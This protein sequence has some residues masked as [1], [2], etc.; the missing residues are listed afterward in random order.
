MKTRTKL[1]L[2]LLAVGGIAYGVEA[3]KTLQPFLQVT[4]KGLEGCKLV[5]APGLQ[6]AEDMEVDPQTGVFFMTAAQRNTGSAF[7]P[8]DGGVFRYRPDVDKAP[9]RLAIEGFAAELRPHGIGLLR[10]PSER[11]VFLIQH[12]ETGESVEI[13]RLEE[14]PER[15]TLRH[16]R[17]VTDP[18][19]K[20]INDVAP[21]A[22]EAFYVT[23]DHGRRG[24]LGHM[25]E[26]FLLLSNASIVYFDGSKGTLAASGL[27]YANG[28]LAD[29]NGRFVLVA[30]TTARRLRAF[31]R[32]SDGT[33]TQ[34]SQRQLTTG[35]DN[36]AQDEQGEYF[37]GAHPSSFQFLRHAKDP[38]RH[39]ASE[40]LRFRISDA[41]EI[42]P[43][44]SF[45]VDDG[46]H[47]SASSVAAAHGS[48]L[49]LGGVFAPGI[50]VC[51]R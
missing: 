37:I 7:K 44:T 32:G 14:T 40:A 4:P 50:L 35:P 17:T 2:A 15:S 43:V 47:L 51:R 31:A 21:V 36:L 27:R 26:D 33:L 20:S 25:F 10:L 22:A 11:R 38:R 41:G 30:E 48:Y 34:V 29:R 46:S 12:G 24:G 42:S 8:R 9:Q 28:V 39:S 18:L 45:L 5:E 49:I 3:Y 19:F 13:F 6:G 16:L 1:A 23:N